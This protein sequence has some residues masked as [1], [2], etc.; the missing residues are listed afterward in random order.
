MQ[1]TAVPHQHLINKVQ[2]LNIRIASG[3]TQYR[4]TFEGFVGNLIELS[5]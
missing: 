2:Q 1:I 4:G 5:E 3:L